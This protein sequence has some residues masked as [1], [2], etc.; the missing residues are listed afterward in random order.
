M[1]N[2]DSDSVEKIHAKFESIHNKIKFKSFGKTRIKSNEN[3]DDKVV[4]DRIIKQKSD[5]LQKEISD[6]KAGS[7]SRPAR[8]FKLI[9]KIKGPK[10][11]GP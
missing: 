11:M 4:I 8:V 3:V 5:I 2:N 6:L 10:K 7:L 1:V 9:E